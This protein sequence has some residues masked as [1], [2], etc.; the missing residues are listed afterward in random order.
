MNRLQRGAYLDFLH[1]QRKFCSVYRGNAAV[2]PD[3]IPENTARLFLGNDFDSVW[4]AL[5]LVLVEKNGFYLI[6]WLKESTDSRELYS[7]KQSERVLKRWTKQDTAVIPRYNRGN[8]VVIPCVIENEIENKI[9][10][11]N[12]D[13]IDEK[14]SSRFSPP[15]IEQVQEY[16]KEKGYADVDA[17]KWWCFYDGKGWMI[18]KNK[19]K[20]WKSA[21]AT[22]HS[23]ED[24][25]PGNRKR[26]VV[27][28]NQEPISIPR[29]KI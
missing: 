23:T 20:N 10:I 26:E 8:T 25:I 24:N 1:A 14:H 17:S 6:P 13:S 18:G 7:K 22:W 29:I 12:H 5:K 2:L 11:N 16:V 19:M 21:V 3:G 9:E 15:T 27:F 4:D 28:E